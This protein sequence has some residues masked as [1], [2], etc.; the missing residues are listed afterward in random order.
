MV[1]TNHIR[2]VLIGATLVLS[3]IGQVQSTSDFQFS[4]CVQNCIRSSG[5]RPNNAR[6]MCR[7]A[8]SLLLDS[9][10]TCLYFNCKSDLVDF[11]DLF[12][13]P[14]EEG[15]EDRG[16]DIP[17]S[18]LEYAESLASSYIS[19]LPRPTTTAAAPKPTSTTAKATTTPKPTIPSTTAKTAPSS[20]SAVEQDD[21]GGSTSTA[22]RPAP[23]TSA[24]SPPP[25]PPAATQPSSS[26]SPSPPPGTPPF[27][28]TNPFAVPSSAGSK[29]GVFSSL[30]A[31]TMIVAMIVWR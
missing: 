29:T 7:A 16:R 10:I 9:V 31:L 22:D 23:T 13:E 28:D 27:G 2:L 4:S 11:E 21:D 15:C 25:P 20:T 17:R 14:I 3:F 30:L 26:A 8:R 5:C 18:K 1:F 12:L 6:C 19:K 24:A